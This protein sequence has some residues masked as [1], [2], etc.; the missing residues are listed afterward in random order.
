[1]LMAEG[2]TERKSIKA[3]AV[4]IRITSDLLEWIQELAE[5]EHRSVSGQTWQLLLEA[6]HY[7]ETQARMPKMPP[8][9]LDAAYLDA[10]P[11][12]LRFLRSERE[13]LEEMVKL[14]P[15]M[16]EFLEEP[17]SSESKQFADG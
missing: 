11:A 3:T 16:R 8:R 2:K 17:N 4:T 5:A 13:K 1:M 10:D 7:R 6:R 14:R 15:E 9:S 12:G